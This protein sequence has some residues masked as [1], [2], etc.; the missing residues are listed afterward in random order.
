V[1]NIP[2]EALKEEGPCIVE[3]LHRVLNFVW[4]NEEI[5]DDWK[6]GL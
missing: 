5:P 3:A 2:P 6:R 4:E 1:D